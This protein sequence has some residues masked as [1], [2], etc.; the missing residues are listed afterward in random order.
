MPRS[1][2][3]PH[4]LALV[5]PGRS[6]PARVVVRGPGLA[7]AAAAVPKH[8]SSWLAV[9]QLLDEWNR[10][11]DVVAEI[12]QIWRREARVTV[13]RVDADGRFAE[14]IGAW[15]VT[16]RW[17]RREHHEPVAAAPHRHA[18]LRRS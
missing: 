9:L 3:P 18:R 13:Y 11:P 17:A 12:S 5:I 1:E 14:E 16:P 15:S 4:G 2:L 10:D 8:P 7:T 6:E